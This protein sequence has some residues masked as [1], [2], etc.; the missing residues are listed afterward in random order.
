MAS[1]VGPYDTNAEEARGH[2]DK[3]APKGKSRPSGTLVSPLDTSEAEKDGHG[4]GRSSKGNDGKSGRAFM[5]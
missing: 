5:S 4:D 2:N 3:S 1:L